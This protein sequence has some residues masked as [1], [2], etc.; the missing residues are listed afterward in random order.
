MESKV[1]SALLREFFASKFDVSGQRSLLSLTSSPWSV[2]F[3]V[4]TG[5]LFSL[6]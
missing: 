1:R 5:I 3:P 6:E 4:D 2:L